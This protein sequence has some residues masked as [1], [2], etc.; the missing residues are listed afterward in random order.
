MERFY[1]RLHESLL[2]SIRLSLM[3]YFLSTLC[4]VLTACGSN[5]KQD[6]AEPTD[7]YSENRARM[8]VVAAQQLEQ[9]RQ[10]L[11][12]QQPEAARKVIK[13]MRRKNYLALDARRRGILLMDSIDLFIAQRELAHTDSLLCSGASS[14]D[15]NDFDEACRKVQFYERK[16]KHDSQNTAR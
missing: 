12:Q 8:E 15:R 2:L 3:K 13:E 7:N 16:I 4:L 5:A 10:L 1:F 9:A 14:V 6:A 11:H